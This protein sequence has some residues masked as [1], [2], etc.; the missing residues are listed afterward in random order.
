MEDLY[1]LWQQHGPKILVFVI[2]FLI[3]SLLVKK[4]NQDQ[5]IQL[6][7]PSSEE[8]LEIEMETS[9]E[10]TTQSS[11][12]YVEILGAIQEPG[13]Y[14]LS[15]GS[16]VFDLVQEAGGLKASA[17]ARSINQAQI[18]EDQMS[19]Y[20]L[21]QDELE[22]N[23]D[24]QTPSVLDV[25]RPSQSGTDLVNINTADLSQ[26]ETLPGIGPSKAQ[27][28]LDHRQK[29]GSFPTIEAIQE[30]SGIGSK[31]YEKLKDLICVD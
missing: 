25:S 24:F 3:F 4:G 18:L 5:S 2:G 27:A 31:T 19:I 9:Q 12:I 21:S 16:R 14:Q 30:V 29:E 20:V 17:Y 6:L 26:L 11:I 8:I 22:S 15:Q 10:G 23:H 28:I 13:V 7:E 1:K